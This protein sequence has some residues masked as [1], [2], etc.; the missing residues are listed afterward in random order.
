[1]IGHICPVGPLG[2]SSSLYANNCM[3][4]SK[5]K[6]PLECQSY[7]DI[8]VGPLLVGAEDSQPACE[9]KRCMIGLLDKTVE[10]KLTFYEFSNAANGPSFFNN[11]STKSSKPKLSK[12]DGW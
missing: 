2:V 5:R 1:M 6:S 7:A 9:F 8:A 11:Y 4:N 12:H 3:V 10:L